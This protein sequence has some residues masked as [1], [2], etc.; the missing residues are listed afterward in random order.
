MAQRVTQTRVDALYTERTKER[1]APGHEVVKEVRMSA[2]KLGAEEPCSAP[3]ASDL[4]P[5]KKHDRHLYLCVCLSTNHLV[6]IF[7]NIF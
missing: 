1:G 5:S 7:K 2:W 3:G 6:D 4:M